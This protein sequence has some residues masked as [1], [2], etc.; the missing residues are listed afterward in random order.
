MANGQLTALPGT[1]PMRI[2]REATEE[3]HQRLERTPMVRQ[4]MDSRENYVLLLSSFYGIYPQLESAI[5]SAE[6]IEGVLPDL[7]SR[8]KAPW[9]SQ[10]LRFLGRDPGLVPVCG[11]LPDTKSVPQALGA[12]YVTE[13]ASLGGQLLCREAA[14]KLGLVS[15]EGVRFFSSYREAVGPMWKEFSRR[16]DAHLQG[17]VL[18]E[19]VGAALAVFGCFENWVALASERTGSA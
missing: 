3:R 11:L 2:L 16:A 4:A 14:R 7:K 1:S 5:E 8:R 13:G 10:D 17:Q 6:G 12:L 9:L 18:D 19:A 15:G